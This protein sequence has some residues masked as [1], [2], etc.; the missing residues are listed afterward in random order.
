M[1]VLEDPNEVLKKLI[2]LEDRSWRY[3]LRFDDLTENLNE[4]WDDC[5]PFLII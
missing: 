2:K 4:T 1:Q 5:D 3:N